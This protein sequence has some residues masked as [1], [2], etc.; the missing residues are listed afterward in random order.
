VQERSRAAGA[1]ERTATALASIEAEIA[2]ALKDLSALSAP[3]RSPRATSGRAALLEADALDSEARR[4]RSRELA[5]RLAR[6]E[7]DR[8]AARRDLDAAKE[9]LALAIRKVEALGDGVR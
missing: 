9:A 8:G 3:A 5:D 1:V 2:A 7:L 4:A 6:L